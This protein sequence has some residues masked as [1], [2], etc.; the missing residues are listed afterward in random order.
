MIRQEPEK[1]LKGDFDGREEKKYID[2]F[3]L[4]TFLT[5]ITT[6]AYNSRFADFNKQMLEV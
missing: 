3:R 1:K 5:W 4:S 6:S 2:Y